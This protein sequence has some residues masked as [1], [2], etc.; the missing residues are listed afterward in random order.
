MI[1][2]T[3]KRLAILLVCYGM[4]ACSWA[5]PL[6]L[7]IFCGD[8]HSTPVRVFEDLDQINAPVVLEAGE[9]WVRQDCVL[10]LEGDTSTLKIE[11]Q[12]ETTL[13]LLDEGPHLDLSHWKHHRSPWEPLRRMEES[14]FLYPGISA[15]RARQFP[16]VTTQEIIRAIP[17]T[18]PAQRRLYWKR[19]ASQ[20]EV[21]EESAHCSV[22]MST[23]R[24]RFKHIDPSKP[25]AQ[26]VLTL[27]LP[28]GC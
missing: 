14:Q 11:R 27:E 6:R 17:R 3:M 16:A 9:E 21:T 8:D 2:Q 7:S 24:L 22:A 4:A 23:I 13:S 19:I 10:K 25:R 26:K 15:E 12:F 20:C 1:A 28:L 5:S 18:L